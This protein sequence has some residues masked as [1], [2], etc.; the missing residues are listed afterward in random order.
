V[1]KRQETLDALWTVTV[2]INRN[3]E[4]FETNVARLWHFLDIFKGFRK[5]VQRVWANVWAVAKAEV[6]E[7]VGAAQV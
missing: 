4:S 5:F 7:V 6:D 1:K 2:W 3:K